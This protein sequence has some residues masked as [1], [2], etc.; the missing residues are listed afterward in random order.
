MIVSTDYPPC[1]FHHQ[2]NTI[3]TLPCQ[4][5]ASSLRGV[6]GKTWPAMAWSVLQ[7]GT[8]NLQWP[9]PYPNIMTIVQMSVRGML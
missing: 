2:Y 5:A 6:K 3:K 8:D 4:E 9:V 7:E 1:T